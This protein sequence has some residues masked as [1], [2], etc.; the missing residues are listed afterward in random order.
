MLPNLCATKS[1]PIFVTPSANKNWSLQLKNGN[2]LNL[3]YFVRLRF[4]VYVRH[5]MCDIECPTFFNSHCP[6]L[7]RSAHLWTMRA[8]DLIC[9]LRQLSFHLYIQRSMQ[10]RKNLAPRLTKSASLAFF[11]SFAPWKRLHLI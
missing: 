6:Y 3:Q 10:N 5:Y 7:C 1:T 4:W 11:I 2:I 9:Y 8:N